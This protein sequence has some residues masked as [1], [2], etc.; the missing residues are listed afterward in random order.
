MHAMALLSLYKTQRADPLLTP[1]S[2]G[3]WGQECMGWVLLDGAFITLSICPAL[4]RMT[5]L[6]K[7][8]GAK[9]QVRR[10]AISR[11]LQGQLHPGL[12]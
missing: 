10:S 9:L 12:Q 11:V 2:L 3:R 5:D 1:P 7:G 8:V 4:D 6:G